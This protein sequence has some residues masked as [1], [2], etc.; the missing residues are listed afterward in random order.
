MSHS[1]ANHVKLTTPTNTLVNYPDVH[2]IGRCTLASWLEP[3][4]STAHHGTRPAQHS[5]ALYNADS[6]VPFRLPLWFAAVAALC[7]VA[8]QWLSLPFGQARLL[9][10]SCAPPP[11]QA[12]DR[13]RTV[14]ACRGDCVRTCG[15]RTRGRP[16]QAAYGVHPRLSGIP[17]ERADAQALFP[18]SGIRQQHAGQRCAPCSRRCLAARG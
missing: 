8:R 7:R 4:C 9:L 6:R 12:Q 13:C 14:S 11:K 10:G 5:L 18:P 17:S 15:P 16:Q 1:L 3:D 2:F